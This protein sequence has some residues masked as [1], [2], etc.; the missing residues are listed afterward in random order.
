MSNSHALWARSAN[1]R[2]GLAGG[3]KECQPVA[4]AAWSHWVGLVLHRA[5]LGSCDGVRVLAYLGAVGVGI[6]VWVVQGDGLLKP[7]GKVYR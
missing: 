1:Q 4:M 5:R 3:D 6:G 7:E 2:G